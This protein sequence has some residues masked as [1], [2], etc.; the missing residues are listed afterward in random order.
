M[1]KEIF[2][3]QQELNTKIGANTRSPEQC[4]QFLTALIHETVE[5]RDE[6]NW[7]WWK[8]PKLVQ[9]N[10][11]QEELID[12]LHFLVSAMIS[13]DMSPE[14]VHHMYLHKN[15]VNHERQE[16]GY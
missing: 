3:K 2:D 13:A 14:L 10:K 4:L 16:N 6:L 15:R 8:Q 7:K 1:L 5:A 12:C 11:L 9:K